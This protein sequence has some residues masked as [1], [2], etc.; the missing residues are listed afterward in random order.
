MLTR[1]WS[2][3]T[4]TATTTTITLLS[5]LRA[6]HDERVASVPE[7][8]YAQALAAKS[9]ESYERTRLSLNEARRRAENAEDDKWRLELENTLRMA[10]GEPE[11]ASL[12]ELDDPEFDD[13]APAE[14]DPLLVEAGEI[15]LDF[16]G[17]ERQVA[18]VGM[19]AAAV[20][21]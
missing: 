11:L 14:D 5:D 9:T 20:V 16:I 2:T 21:Q 18:M 3:S 7:F 15:L 1:P 10:K 8:A 12:D 13:E 19:E 6:R 4:S 17:L